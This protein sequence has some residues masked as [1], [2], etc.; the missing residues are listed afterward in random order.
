MFRVRKRVITRFLAFLV[1]NN[2]L[3]ASVPISGANLDLYPEDDILPH[4]EESV[5]LNQSAVPADILAQ[6]TA[7]FE[8]HPA[9]LGSSRI[10]SFEPAHLTHD[11]HV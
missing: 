7:S 11:V 1:A 9:N 10:S 2:P 6:E 3:Y 4:L 5:I 8:L